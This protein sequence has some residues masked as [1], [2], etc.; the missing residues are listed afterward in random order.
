MS[1]AI[2]IG[3]TGLVGKC[4]VRQLLA[5]PRYTRVIALVR[6]ATA[7]QH[8]KYQEHMVNFDQPAS[9]A[10]RVVGDALFSSMGTT[11]SQAG[12]VAAQRT[13][14]YTYQLEVAKLAAKNGVR[15]YVLVSSGGANPSS[16]M[17]YLKMKGELERDVR[18]LGFATL[19]ILRPGVLKGEREHARRAEGLAEAAIGT[20]NA[21]GLLRSARP[22][23]GE[24]VAVAMRHA[25]TLSGTRVHEPAE[26]FTPT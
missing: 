7:V 3:A 26:L 15:T 12:S 25:A 5:D 9:F 2:V 11:R 18:S 10:E 24:Q 13:V 19:Q 4:L 16:L 21:I 17:A 14:D 23:T 8:E 6:R 22:I 1:T 20:L